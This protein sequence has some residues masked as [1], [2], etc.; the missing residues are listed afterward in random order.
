L[1]YWHSSQIFDPGWN[2]S[3]YQNEDL[4]KLLEQ[5]RTFS[6]PFD[7]ERIKKLEEIQDTIIND[8]P[9][10]FLYSANYNYI[11]NKKV[12][13]FSIKKAIDQSRVFDDITNWYL[14]EQRVWK[15]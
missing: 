8:A 12:K 3:V 15:K 9:A 4:D 14:N 13:G 7:E 10:I 11:L 5:S 2:L 1:P 6:N